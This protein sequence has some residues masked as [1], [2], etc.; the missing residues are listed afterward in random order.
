VRLK[1]KPGEA[2]TGGDVEQRSVFERQ[3]PEDGWMDGRT[4]GRAGQ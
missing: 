1:L 3:R 2:K 4:D